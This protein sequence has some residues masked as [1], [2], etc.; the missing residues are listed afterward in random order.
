MTTQAAKDS[1]LQT[2][3]GY[4]RLAETLEAVQGWDEIPQHRLRPVPLL[5]FAPLTAAAIY[6][7]GSPDFR[8]RTTVRIVFQLRVVAGTPNSLSIWP[9]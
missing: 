6:L 3:Q 8:I 2:A 1:L 4:D 9:R 7:P 5:R